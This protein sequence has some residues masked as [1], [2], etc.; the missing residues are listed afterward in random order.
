MLFLH[1]YKF[2]NSKLWLFLDFDCLKYYN[3]NEKV[4]KVFYEKISNTTILTVIKV[5]TWIDK[6]IFL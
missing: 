2:F 1:L 4:R 5:K 3:D 6:C